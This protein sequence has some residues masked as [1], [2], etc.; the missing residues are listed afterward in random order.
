LRNAAGCWQ[1]A[2]GGGLLANSDWR[3]ANGRP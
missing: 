3:L 2:T 1:L